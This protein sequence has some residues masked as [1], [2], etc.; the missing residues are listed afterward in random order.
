MKKENIKLSITILLIV[1]FSLSVTYAWMELSANS[2]TSES[3][4]GCFVVNYNGQEINN[5]SLRSTTN[6]LEGASSNIILSKNSNCKIYTEA[7]IY[8]HTNTEG[9]TLYSSEENENKLSNGALK[10]K[11]VKVEGEGQTATETEISTGSITTVG[12]TLLN[13]EEKITLT[14]YYITY[15]VYLW[16]DPEVSKGSYNGKTYSGYLYASSTQSSTVKE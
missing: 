7:S 1:V 9:T 14:D 10:Y 13:A 11:L 5:Q 2:N 6:Y 16:I 3:Q 8:I 4:S 15:K 12:D